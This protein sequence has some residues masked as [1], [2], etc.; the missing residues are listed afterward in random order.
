MRRRGGGA[1]EKCCIFTGDMGNECHIRIVDSTFESTDTVI[2][3]QSE[4]DKPVSFDVRGNVIQGAGGIYVSQQ[5]T[6]V[7]RKSAIKDNTITTT[8]EGI[9]FAYSSNEYKLLSIE[10]NCFLAGT[11]AIRI[12]DVGKV[13]ITGNNVSLCDTGIVATGTSNIVAN[14]ITA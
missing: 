6:V 13:V 14:N 2:V 5:N 11:Y 9:H 12:Y 8:R 1:S 4:S 10:H 7:N 3:I